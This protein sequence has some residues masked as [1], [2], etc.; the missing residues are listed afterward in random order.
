MLKYIL[1]VVIIS[2][3]LCVNAQSDGNTKKKKSKAFQ[4]LTVS[5]KEKVSDET[6]FNNDEQ[7]K[8]SM[9]KACVIYK[10]I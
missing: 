1:T 6:L 3:A 9:Y 10:N 7:S 5:D 2:F 8:A 4:A